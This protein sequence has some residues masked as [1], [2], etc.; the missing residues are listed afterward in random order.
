LNGT[1]QPLSRPVFIYVS[2]R[3]ASRPEVREF[4][5]FYLTHA[6]SLV[7]QVGYVPLPDAVY[8]LALPRFEQGRTGSV[9]SGKGPQVGVKL[10]DLLRAEQQ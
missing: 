8:N 9:F 4:V 6:K 1:Y 7:E 10:E 5:R 3:A 2:Q